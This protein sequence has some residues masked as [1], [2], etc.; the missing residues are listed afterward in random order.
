MNSKKHILTYLLS[1]SLFLILNCS[2]LCADEL[3]DNLRDTSEKVARDI[4]SIVGE[5]N[6]YSGTI[7]F[8]NRAIVMGDLFSDLLSNRLL[9]NSRFRGSVFKAYSPGAFR[10]SDAN[11]IL[12]GSLYRMESSYFLSLYLFDNAGKQKKGWELL[13][14]AEGTDVLLGVSQG[15]VSMGG[16]IYEPNDD[17]QSAVELTPEPSMELNDLTLGDTDDED[18]FYIDLDPLDDESLAY[19]LTV[20]TTG[21]LDTYLEIY[22]PDDTSYPVAQNDDGYDN[23]AGINFA[24]YEPGRWYIKVRGYSGDSGDYGLTVSLNMG[25]RGPGEPDDSRADAAA[26]EIEKD[27]LQRSIDFSEDYDYFKITLDQDLPDDKVLVVQTY[28]GMDIVMTLID[29]YDNEVM[30][31][32]DSGDDDNPKVMVSGLTAGTWYAVVYPHDSDNIGGSYTIRAYLMDI[33]KDD[34]E[35]DNTMEDA[36]DIEIDGPPQERFFILNDIEDWVRIVVDEPGDFI[37]RTSGPT[38]TY[39]TLYD[40]YGDYIYEDDDSGNDSNAQIFEH[41]DEGVYYLQVIQY[42]GSENVKSIYSLSVRR[43]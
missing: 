42:S 43:F 18:W 37:I 21:G 38:D 39:M 30:T 15:A 7:T 16:D 9:E 35:N 3:L 36:K 32:D 14:P 6:L 31:D 25:T 13:L 2:A 4:V 10:L 41:L 26:L 27:E 5:G 29:E 34:F 17:I 23:N 22:S 11:W 24:I 1:A 19:I 12:S 33:E 28:S 20:N 40:H 8:E